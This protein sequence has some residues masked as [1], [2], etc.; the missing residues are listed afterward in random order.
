MMRPR[1][2]LL[3]IGAVFLGPLVA[4][5]IWYYALGGA[6]SRPATSNYA[7]LVTPPMALTAFANARVVDSPG[8]GASAW[9]EGDADSTSTSPEAAIPPAPFTLTALKHRWSML[10]ML[11]SECAAACEKS[12]YHTRQVRL[13]LGKDSHRIQRIFVSPSAALLARLAAAHPDAIGVLES[14]RGLERQLAPIIRRHGLTAD[15]ALLAD[16]LGNLM[17]ILP[18]KLAPRLLL[19]DFKRLLRLSRIG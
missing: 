6:L 17:L 7:P 12:L 5:F 15:D 14:P 9:L 16:P 8:D 2:K 10:H 13:A 3:I 11:T 4:A 19:K 18:A 1:I